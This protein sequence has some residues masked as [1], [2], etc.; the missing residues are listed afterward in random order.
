MELRRYSVWKAVA[1]LLVVTVLAACGADSP[2]ALLTSAK[3]YLAKKDRKAAVIQ[4]KS[5]LQK[6]PDLA[7]ARFLLGRVLLDNGE[8]K[9]AENELRKAMDLKFP[10]DQ[11]VP[12]L[13]RTLLLEGEFK[14]ITEEVGKV[15]LAAPEARADLQTTIGQ[16][17]LALGNAEAARKAFAAAL[18][19]QPE[20]AQA[21]LG[22][23]RLKASEH[24]LPGALEIAEAVLA[25]SPQ[26]AEAWQLKGDILFAQ[27]QSDVALNAYR[28]AIESKAD[29]LP[30]HA[31]IVSLL[32]QQG[33]LEEAGKQL[34][35]M[36]QVAPKHPQTLY[37]EALIAYR[38]RNFA[39]AREAIQ[40]HL[41]SL[42]DNLPG[43]LLSG[44]IDYELKSYAQAEASLLKV[45]QRAPDQPLARRSLI[46]TY[47]RSGQPANAWET[48]QPVLDK[49]DKD[50]DMLSLAGEVL[51]QNG[52]AAEAAA[53]FEKA[54]ALDPK[55]PEKRTAV[56]LSRMATGESE[57]GLHELE[58]AAAGDTGTR[59][60]TAL[61]AAHLQ[62]REYDKALKAIDALE[63]KQPADPLAHNLRGAALLAKH[64]SAGA[65][66]SFERALEINPTYFPAAANLARLDM[67]EK[68]P[69]EARKRFEALLAREPKNTQALLALAD[70]RAQAGA[71][72]EE[73][74]A[75]IGKAVA[76]NPNESAP[77]LALIANYQRVKEPKKALAA[78]QEAL[79]ALPDRPEILDAT[80]LAQQ[81]AGETNQAIATYSKL[82]V[83]QP[84]S[85]TPFLRLAAVQ[86]AAKDT[87]GAL[88]T[89]RKALAI[90]PG[91]VEAQRAMIALDLDA[92]R[93]PAAI[94]L[95]R[96]VQKQRPTQS[97]GFI[98]EGDIHASK[99]A[100]NEAAA[101][102]RE[103]L[104]QVGAADLAIKL[105]GALGAGGSG[106]EADKLAAT[107]LK[108]HPKDEVFRFYLAQ[109]ATAQK[110]YRG[111]SQH[112]VT[113][114]ELHPDS[115]V[116]LNN[117][118]WVAGQLK[119]PKALEYAE[120]ANKLAP[121]NPA[122]MD[123]LGMLL[124][125]G[126]EAA[127]GVELLR[128]AA[129]L[130]PQEATIRLDLAKA[131][132]KTGQKAAAKKELDTLAKLGD[133][134]PAQ[135]EVEQL[136][137]GL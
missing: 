37:L 97:V 7:E 115:P 40:Q 98:L 43:M 30:A 91:L 12:P 41:K 72:A 127:R 100:W 89:L 62:R 17:Q 80:G 45:L 83:L 29:F 25:K 3:E 33:K 8:A 133:K 74:A 96:E 104:K 73:V 57:R 61:I 107:W 47:L 68:K 126:G 77:R 103:G 19:S 110:D 23:A 4:L 102:Y 70:L 26:L 78:A 86:A 18:D 79:A 16:A 81:A 108:D 131:L 125:D 101:A 10:A 2:E 28:K 113:L 14:K 132:I 27:G 88:Q 76:A 13:A 130:A 92:G 82:A 39:L 136:A 95:A 67:A 31:A 56:A 128:K 84:N 87:D 120:K 36:K 50:A 69:D 51:M 22:Q 118:A 85:P 99:K 65:R 59:A 114:L 129:G 53:Y 15:D 5:A 58:E 75:L 54:A 117:L 1:P 21:R 63:K 135:A 106:T 109:T 111:A 32:A 46:A 38:Q 94:A 35:A 112:Y 24:D 137:K 124:M 52:R 119:E 11:V 90:K 48:L 42:P 64:D 49:I 134:F 93:M 60:D 9:A 34:E 44:A 105:H 71:S 123:T 122:I 116:I 121:D 66:R 6:S 20:N 55:N